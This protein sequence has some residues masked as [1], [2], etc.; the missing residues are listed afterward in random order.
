MKKNLLRIISALAAA[1]L[2]LG[3][4]CGCSK[5]VKDAELRLPL[6]AEPTVLDPQVASGAENKTI[7]FNCFEGLT[8][9]DS[10]GNVALAAASD[11]AVS[12][13]GLTYVFRLH[14]DKKWH[15][16]SNH[17]EI[18][19]EDWETA[20]DLRVTADDFVFGLQ[21]ALDPETK[22][23]DAKRLYMIKNAEKVNS[24]ELPVSALGVTAVD[25]FTVQITLEYASGEF[26]ETL[27]EPVSMPCKQAFFEA[28]KGK[29]GLA[30]QYVLCNGAFYLSRWYKGSSIVLRRNTDNPQAQAKVYSVTYAFTQNEEIILENLLDGSYS[31]AKLSKTAALAAEKEGCTVLEIQNTVWGLAFN[32]SDE[33]MRSAKL[34]LALIKTFDFNEIFA[35]AGEE[36]SARAASIV[37]PSC[38]V[39]G[40]AFNSVAEPVG[41]LG[42]D[43]ETARKYY[44][45][46][47]GTAECEISVLCT[48]QFE[49]AVRRTIQTWQQVFGIKLSARV[50]VLEES[51]L[52]KR[53]ENGNYQC[54]LTQITTQ[55][56]SPTEFLT[57]LGSSS[58]IF[59][60]N[61]SGFN[62]LLDKLRMA[63]GTA[64]ML[65][66]C[67]SAQDYLIQN[68]VFCPL[69]Y[70]SSYV[71]AAKNMQGVVFSHSGSIIKLNEAEQLK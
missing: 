68:G 10:S 45:E 51:E 15:I 21:R 35:L 43:E 24:G 57:Q 9:L 64:S 36:M 56:Q 54:A 50:E 3:G 32:C 55:A 71:A 46:A 34:R 12:P 70:R 22:A 38:E 4:L 42:Y 66:G 41:L 39:D 27:S 58:G 59:R 30:A 16:N 14:T 28:T 69:F 48:A 6:A 47:V 25:E 13:D 62:G 26:L 67:K 2:C 53:V 5:T 29:N 40:Q 20:I 17:E 18:F 11:L 60:Y 33:A 23:P 1:V 63:S 61:S 44:D 19:G 52:L 7:V 37:P 31:A 8:K 65:E 49:T